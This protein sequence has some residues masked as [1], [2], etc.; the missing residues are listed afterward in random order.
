VSTA[1]AQYVYGVVSAAGD[2]P[3]AAGIGGGAVQLVKAGEIA[4]LVSDID[5]EE[6]TLGR[7]AMTAH[8]R[9]LEDA[10]AA[11]TVLPMRF[12]VVMADADAVRTELLEARNSELRDQLEE[13]AGK[14]ELRVR[15]TYEEDQLMREAVAQD[16]E[17]LR[18]RDSLRGVPEDAT[19]YARIQLGELVAG[20]VERSR[21]ADADAI[22]AELSPL[23]V[24]VDVGGQAHERIALNA[25]FLVER[26]RID[27]FD[28]QVDRIG[29]AQAGR[30]RFKYVGPLPPHSF[31]RLASAGV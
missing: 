2:P 8:E 7:E 18:L 10:L 29:R 22:L 24:A 1:P 12:G 13:L 23:A 11:G 27:T 20:A 4:A 5:R 31:V 21:Q 3:S 9:V 6:L 26:E 30:L 17:I 19:Y 28:Q 16:P 25:S 14:I 15:A